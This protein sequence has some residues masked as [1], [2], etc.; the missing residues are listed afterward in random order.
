[1]FPLWAPPGKFPA[2]FPNPFS[3]ALDGGHPFVCTA[4]DQWGQ[5][6]PRDNDGDGIAVPEVGAVEG[7]VPFLDGFEIGS[8]ANWSHTY[9]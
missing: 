4:D 3:A 7:S 9:D 5:F 2:R 6:R 8:S 1:M